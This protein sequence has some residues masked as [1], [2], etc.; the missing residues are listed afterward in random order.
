MALLSSPTKKMGHLVNYRKTKAEGGVLVFSSPPPPPPSWH[1]KSQERERER[2]RCE[3]MYLTFV[4]FRFV[5]F[6]SNLRIFKHRDYS[7][8]LGSLL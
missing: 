7:N 3:K 5:S 8:N 2:E 4:L 6:H 1:F